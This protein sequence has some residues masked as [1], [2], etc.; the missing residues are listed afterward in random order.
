MSVLVVDNEKPWFEVTSLHPRVATLGDVVTITFVASEPLAVDPLAR[1]LLQ[2]ALERL[3]R[4]EE[5]RALLEDL[6][7]EAEASAPAPEPV[8]DEDAQ[9]GSTATMNIGGGT[10]T[11]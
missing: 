9:A 11:V 8:V 5:V 2:E 10:F 7:P 4:W 1:R 6:P 3:D